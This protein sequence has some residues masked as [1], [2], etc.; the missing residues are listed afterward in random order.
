MKII[1]KFLDG[2]EIIMLN[3]YAIERI[4]GD[5]QIKQ[6][7]RAFLYN[8]TLFNADKIKDIKLCMN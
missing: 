6:L 5:I 3:V 4:N 1:I 7:T 8:S 2:R